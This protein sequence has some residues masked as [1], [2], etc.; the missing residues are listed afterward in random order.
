MQRSDLTY[1]LKGIQLNFARGDR[2][3]PSNKLSVLLAIRSFV[4]RYGKPLRVF[5]AQNL[6]FILNLS[7]A[8]TILAHLR[9]NAISRGRSSPTRS[10][11]GDRITLLLRQ[12]ITTI[13]AYPD[14]IA[15]LWFCYDPMQTS[16]TTNRITTMTARLRASSKSLSWHPHLFDDGE[17]NND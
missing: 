16:T 3:K 12:N 6:L 17:H 15:L 11:S 14:D 13:T 2:L 7:P 10:E 8:N 9:H 1:F 4:K 5:L